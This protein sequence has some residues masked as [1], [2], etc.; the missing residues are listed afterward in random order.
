LK[1]RKK[2]LKKQNKICKVLP[3]L[4]DSV[5]NLDEPFNQSAE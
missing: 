4:W 1:N 5:D 3:R 2:A